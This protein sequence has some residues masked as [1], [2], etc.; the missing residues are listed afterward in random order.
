MLT[1]SEGPRAQQLPPQRLPPPARPIVAAEGQELD[2]VRQE[3][4]WPD[5]ICL[6]HERQDL[7]EEVLRYVRHGERE[8]GSENQ[9]ALAQVM[10][11]LQRA[12]E[13]EDLIP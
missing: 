2:S 8:V 9:G 5:W 13:P 1:S 12:D 11:A 4:W 7:V 3:A 10:A 6:S